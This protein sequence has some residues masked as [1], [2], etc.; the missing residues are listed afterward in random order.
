M[1]YHFDL[2]AIA[3][4]K[5]IGWLEQGLLVTIG[6]SL[7]VIVASTI[8]GILLAV[9]RESGSRVLA[10]LTRA[11]QDV[12]RNTPLLVQLF[13][14]YFGASQLIPQPPMQWLNTPH[15]WHASF[16]SVSWPSFEFL[17]STFGLTLFSGAF[18]AE[19]LRGGIQ[20]IPRGQWQAAAALGMTRVQT[21]GFV[22]VPQAIRIALAPLFGQYLNIIKNSSLAIAIG[23]AELS[24]QA[25]EIETES[26]RSFEAFGVA[27]ALYIVIL[28]IVAGVGELLD[29]FAFLRG[30]RAGARTP[31]D[32]P[33]RP[34]WWRR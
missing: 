10:A 22:I 2:Q 5:Y 14:W 31:F 20:S 6:L 24:Y 28:G 26:F 27:T 15:I 9:G 33:M 8:W 19:E 17:A 23:L 21:M 32:Q 18:I 4:P 11:Y 7:S 25:R 1:A 3:T 30:V 34:F 13:F 29:G 12:F 16:L